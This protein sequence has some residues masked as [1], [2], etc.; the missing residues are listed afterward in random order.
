MYIFWNM[1]DLKISREKYLVIRNIIAKL[2]KEFGKEEPLTVNKGLVHE[3]LDM[4][5]GY[6]K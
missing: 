4:T 1:D 6:R 3:Y 5:I 2:N